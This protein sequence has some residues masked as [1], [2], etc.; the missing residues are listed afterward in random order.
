MKHHWTRRG[1]R[2]EK[3]LKHKTDGREFGFYTQRLDARCILSSDGCTA[4]R[5]EA[6]Q[7]PKG[8]LV[9]SEKSLKIGRAEGGSFEF[10]VRIDGIE[11]KWYGLPLLG[12]TRREPMDSPDLYPQFGMCLGQS[13]LVG[14][15]GNAFARDQCSN[16]VIGFKK[17]PQ[18][19][20]AV[21][22]PKQQQLN[23]ESPRISIGDILRCVYT[24][25]GVIQLWLNLEKIIEVDTERHIDPSASYYAVADVCYNVNSLTVIPSQR[26][27]VTIPTTLEKAR[28]GSNASLTD[29]DGESLPTIYSGN[30]PIPT[31]D[32][33]PLMHDSSA[34]KLPLMHEQS[35]GPTTSEVVLVQ[36]FSSTDEDDDG[37]AQQTEE[38]N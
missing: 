19:E 36:H 23:S 1:H 25:L 12:F 9:F 4:T 18:D 26:T 8:C 7:L 5:R 14:Y 24:R 33:L 11:P 32:S 2:R 28:Q 21:L 29:F 30:S 38:A 13:V 3:L 34:E 6:A 22:S 27:Y 35:D 15:D 16:F 17:P 31:S 10:S 37:P 20:I